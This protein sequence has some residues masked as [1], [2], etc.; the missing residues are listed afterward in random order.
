MPQDKGLAKKKICGGRCER[1]YEPGQQVETCRLCEKSSYKSI[2]AD[3]ECTTCPGGTRR[4][5]DDACAD[6]PCY[7]SYQ[8]TTRSEGATSVDECWCDPGMYLDLE[9]S[10]E[11]DA[12][13]EC[14]AGYYQPPQPA[15]KEHH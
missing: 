13:V 1:G 12:C 5:S 11:A 2:V 9:R 8:R 3:D 14:S 6:P 7:D 10:D 15:R 4:V